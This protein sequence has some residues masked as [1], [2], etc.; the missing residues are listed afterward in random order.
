MNWVILQS[1]KQPLPPASSADGEGLVAIGGELTSARLKE[2]YRK[3]IYPWYEEDSPVLWWSPDPRMVLFPDQLHIP[4]SMRPLL[5]KD[6][7]KV[8]INQAFEDVIRKCAET[9]R[10]D[11]DGTWIIDEMIDAYIHWHEEGF[12]HSFEAWYGE[13]LVG[14]FYGV[15]LGRVFFGES[16][17]ALAPNAS[18]FAFIKGVQWMRGNG[19]ELI[20]CQMETEHL[21]RF[22]AQTID[23]GVFVEEVSRLIQSPNILPK[24]FQSEL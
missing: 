5:N 14:G 6:A 1:E 17:F 9:A 7:F 21:K 24:E 19:I 8:T 10:P 3:G 2:A 16:M 22:G 15:N 11:Q 13:D 20:D 12:V 4:K 18:K 23:R